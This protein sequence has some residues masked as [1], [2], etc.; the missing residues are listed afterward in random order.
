[1]CLMHA[2][3]GCMHVCGGMKAR[4]R[5][6]TLYATMVAY[7]FPGAC[8]CTPQCMRVHAVVY[9][10]TRIYAFAYSRIYAF[11]YSR[12]Y[13][14]SYVYT[15]IYVYMRKHAA[16]YAYCMLACSSVYISY[17]YTCNRVCVCIPWCMRMHAILPAHVAAR[18]DTM[19]IGAPTAPPPSLPT[20]RLLPAPASAQSCCSD[21]SLH[22]RTHHALDV[23]SV[24]AP[25]SSASPLSRTSRYSHLTRARGG[26]HLADITNSLPPP[27]RG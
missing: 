13:A 18:V 7:A 3:V 10:Y 5:A 20:S 14:Y 26:C 22:T 24:P 23:C 16:V 9:T 4:V 17:A 8:V 21:T 11:A 2:C 12:I 6:Q 15:D 25:Y 27:S 19:S 1:M